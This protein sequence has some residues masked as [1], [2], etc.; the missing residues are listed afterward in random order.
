ML[1]PVLMQKSLEFTSDLQLYLLDR[2]EK[3]L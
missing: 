3:S 2:S 1:H